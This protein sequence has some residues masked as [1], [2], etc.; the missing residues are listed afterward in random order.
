MIEEKNSM[1]KFYGKKIQR[2]LGKLKIE[3]NKEKFFKI[4]DIFLFSQTTVA[5]KSA[6]VWKHL[7]SIFVHQNRERL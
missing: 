6:Q 1:N 7:F 5:Q 3:I 2:I 4:F